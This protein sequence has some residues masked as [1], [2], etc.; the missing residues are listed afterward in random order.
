MDECIVCG[1]CKCEFEGAEAC[2]EC[3]HCV[4]CSNC[5]PKEEYTK[6]VLVP[7]EN[8]PDDPKIHSWIGYKVS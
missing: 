2:K 7:A 1:C 5:C 4:A 3:G 6:T 8:V